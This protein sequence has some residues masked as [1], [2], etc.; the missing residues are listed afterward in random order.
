MTLEPGQKKV[1]S[2]HPHPVQGTALTQG[3]RGRAG[4]NSGLEAR[5]S[6]LGADLS[7]L[8]RGLGSQITRKEHLRGR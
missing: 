4:L 2:G 7:G 3:Q 5:S 6:P 1:E 8:D